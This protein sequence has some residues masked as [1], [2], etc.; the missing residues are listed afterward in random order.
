VQHEQAGEDCRLGGHADSMPSTKQQ[1]SLRH[2]QRTIIEAALVAHAM[3]MPPCPNP[4]ATIDLSIPADDDT[5]PPLS[6]ARSR[7]CQAQQQINHKQKPR[8]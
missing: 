4:P 8:A 3:L 2:T 5:A 1:Y 6:C 7:S